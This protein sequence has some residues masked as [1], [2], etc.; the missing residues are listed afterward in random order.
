M[1]PVKSFSYRAFHG[2]PDIMLGLPTIPAPQKQQWREVDVSYRFHLHQHPYIQ[3]L[4]ASLL[5]GGIPSLQDVDTQYKDATQPWSVKIELVGSAEFVVSSGSQIALCSALWNEDA[6]LKLTDDGL[7]RLEEQASIRL[8]DANGKP[9]LLLA[10]SVKTRLAKG[11]TYLLKQGAKAQLVGSIRALLKR[12][13]TI[14]LHN[15]VQVTIPAGSEVV[16]GAST[17]VELANSYPSVVLSSSPLPKNLYQEFFDGYKPTELV[18]RPYPVKELDFSRGGAYSVYNWEL[19]FHVPFLLAVQLSRNQRFAEAQAWFHFI[20][21]P[22]DDSE[23][24]TP[25]RFWKARPFHCTDL[26]RV[27]E[28]LVNLATKS[29]QE[30]SDETD[31]SLQEWRK[32]P[33]RPHVAARLRPQ[34]YMYK[35]VMA[36]VD[37]L[38][39]WGDSLFRQDTGEAIDEALQLYVLAANILGPR[40]QVVPRKG[41]VR[42]HTYAGLR[43]DMAVFGTVLRDVEAAG[44]FDIGLPGRNIDSAPLSTVHSLATALYFC[45]PRNDKLLAY[46]DTVADR[47]F[48]I[49]NSLSLQGTFRQ[50]PLYEP[51]IDPAL[52][53][54]AVAAGLD[55]GAVVNG[56]NQPLPLVRFHV[57]AQKALEIAQEVRSLGN[58]LLSLMEKEDGE[59]L[60]IL[61]AK[62]ER[63]VMDM[64]ERVKYAQ[65]QEAVKSREGVQRSF[66]LAVQRYAYYERQLGKP[67]DEIKNSLP[68]LS[69]LDV[70]SLAEMRLDAQEPAIVPREIEIDIAEDLGES[71]GKIISSHELNELKKLDSA[72]KVQVT[73]GLLESLGS[74]LAIIPQF[75]ADATPM[76]PESR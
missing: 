68:D 67:L 7:F 61:R 15:G 21:N 35:T 62:H 50:L 18:A 44:P 54:R 49:R 3:E 29:D 65:S 73:A 34:A 17:L 56:L 31:N 64:V 75:K 14:Q 30:L 24:P 1:N 33:F 55:I 52:L 13:T 57:L 71:G 40:P 46:W 25:D 2:S 8:S 20:F 11:D 63:T 51:P 27:E 12:D 72:Q 70:D 66:T 37:N 36:Y 59:A 53:A 5:R 19:F 69:D 38:V 10:E 76:P 41:S 22:A 60:A 32:N 4:Q 23:A 9:R 16:L 39:A 26:S 28:I 45:V 43:K 47:L 42:P 6:T 74:V 58:S 48:K